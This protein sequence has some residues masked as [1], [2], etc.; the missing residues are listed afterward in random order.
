MR[1]K[2]PDLIAF[3]LALFCGVG[4][5][6]CCFYSYIRTTPARE[7]RLSSGN[8][9][10]VVASQSKQSFVGELSPWHADVNRSLQ[11]PLSIFDALAPSVDEFSLEVTMPIINGLQLT[12]HEVAHLEES[13]HAIVE[14]MQKAEI[15]NA[16]LM[17]E[18]DE[19]YY[20]IG[21]CVSRQ[22]LA[23]EFSAAVDQIIGK[24]RGYVFF[25]ALPKVIRDYG[26][27]ILEIGFVW[28][29]DF[30]EQL[31]MVTQLDESGAIVKESY[32][33]Q[34]AGSQPGG[35]FHSL[36]TSSIPPVIDSSGREST[37]S[38]KD[39]EIFVDPLVTERLLQYLNAIEPNTE[40]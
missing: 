15:E 10:S 40:E 17:V 25:S 23:D 34:S 21:S 7:M 33:P 35:R 20:S 32:W 8:R 31:L 22:A 2:N 14:K 18:N 9:T 36:L 24:E 37:I 16:S 3:A 29:K 27:T 6:H 26:S 39:L 1:V 28:H 12:Q 19:E 4:L 13:L 5:G 38:G 11:L 30:E